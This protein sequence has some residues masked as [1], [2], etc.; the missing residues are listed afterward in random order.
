MRLRQ[1]SIALALALSATEAGA[2]GFGEI[3]VR[4]RLNEPL[5][6]WIRIASADEEE[7]ATLSV[8]LATAEDYSRMGLRQRAVPVAVEFS[9]ERD[10][11]GRPAIRVRS[12][13]PVREPLLPLLVEAQ[14]SKG[15]MFR[16]FV[17]LLDPPL[18]VPAVAK[19]PAVRPA[20]V[21]DQPAPAPRER[22][23]ARPEE[24]PSPAE[25]APSAPVL[26]EPAEPAPR[27]PA[28]ERPAAAPAGGES[29]TPAF[30]GGEYG[31]V[32][33]GETL[34]QIALATRPAEVDVQQMLVAIFD[35][36]PGAFIDGNVNLLRRGAV[37]RIP[38]A[39]EVRAIDRAEARRRLAEHSEAWLARRGA[40]APARIAAPPEPP[41]VL[42]AREERVAP[43]R[44][45]RPRREDRLAILPPAG[46]ETRSRTAAGG[47]APARD[48]EVE[49]LRADLQRSRESLAAAEQE[50][51][52]LRSRVRELEA[53]E[54]DQQRL[55]ALKDTELANLRQRLAELEERLRAAEAASTAPQEAPHAA[56]A[57]PVEPRPTEAPPPSEPVQAAPPAPQRPVASAPPPA[58]APPAAPAPSPPSEEATP[59]YSNPAVIG[60]GVAVLL[61]ALALAWLMRRRASQATG[62]KSLASRLVAAAP[63]QQAQAEDRLKELRA[64]VEANPTDLQAHLALLRLLYNREDPVAFEI[65]AESMAGYVGE[66]PSPE[67]EEVLAMGREIA[68]EHPLFR[69]APATPSASPDAAD[70]FAPSVEAAVPE[71]QEPFQ[72]APEE[73]LAAPTPL[74]ELEL[75]A[76]QPEA[77]EEK[78]A[79][80]AETAPAPE[81]FADP[82]T[83]QRMQRPE[84]DLSR[85]WDTQRISQADVDRAMA[86]RTPAA[87]GVSLGE[88]EDDVVATKLDLARE[89]L[90]LG[91]A[92]GARGLLE[93]VLSEGTPKQKAEAQRLL[94]QI[95]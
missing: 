25:P 10:R 90:D 73:T 11:Q 43:P 46:E 55:I 17:V 8:R 91:D 16:E 74:P 62:E 92:D 9:V 93:E 64:A 41:P 70:L 94:A 14:W 83:T 60:G 49:A 27:A 28:P 44:E 84:L 30:A 23:P 50:L 42:A 29:R 19:A 32:A 5:D 78:P 3:E 7:L 15:R 89:Y 12:R 31:P 22:V 33:S 53:I 6:A 69:R 80:P 2:L 58:A 61:L 87:S 57:E 85:E 1:L 51:G 71:E 21:E 72:G 82:L 24:A 75:P 81:V 48:A 68:P 40:V 36:N 86:D 67:W 26:A 35:A 54:S 38:G 20:R 47:G 18:T 56:V 95:R 79:P 37:L 66:G 52:E 34:W 59:W 39:E 13:Q 88:S 4:S 63:P 77:E 65:A 76:W 45:D